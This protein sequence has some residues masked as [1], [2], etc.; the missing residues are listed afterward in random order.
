MYFEDQSVVIL[1]SLQALLRTIKDI[2]VMYRLS[3]IAHGT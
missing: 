3:L 1:E 2:A